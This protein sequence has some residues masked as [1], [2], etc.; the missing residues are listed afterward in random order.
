MTDPATK[1]VV[2]TMSE[3]DPKLKAGKFKDLLRYLG[4]GIIV[5]PTSTGNGEIFSTSREGSLFGF[6]LLW[7]S[8][9]CVIMKGSVAYTGSKFATLTDEHPATR[10]G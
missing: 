8:L 1:S 3:P 7:T 10:R 9:L 6:S 4:P 5:V 2:V